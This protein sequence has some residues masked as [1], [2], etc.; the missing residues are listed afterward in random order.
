MTEPPRLP[1]ELLDMV[2]GHASDG[3]ADVKMLCNFSLVSSR[4]YAAL[5]GRIYS[6]WV[7]DGEHHS[8][9]SLWKFLRSVLTSRRIA[10]AVHELDIR[11]W[12]LGLV[13]KSGRLVF[14]D[15]DVD[16]IRNAL[17]V[18]GLERIESSA[19]EALQKADPRPLMA[20]LLA[21]LPNLTT[22][23]AHLPDEDMFFA[24]VLQKA[25]EGRQDKQASN[26]IPLLNRLC[27]VHLASAWNYRGRDYQLRVKHLSHV[28]QLPN[29]QE[30]SVFDLEPFEASDRFENSPRSSNITNLT[31]VH[32]TQSLLE[33]PDTLALLALPRRLTKLSIYLNDND[34][35]GYRNQISNIDLWSGIRKHEASLEHLDIYR[36]CDGD[37]PEC[38]SRN[39]SYFGL[40]RGFTRLRHLYIQPE[41]LL[42]GCCKGELAPF[43]LQDTLPPNLESLTLYGYEG[44]VFIKTLSQ[45]LEKVVTSTDFPLLGYVAMERKVPRPG[46]YCAR[47]TDPP[48]HHEVR[49]ACREVGKKYEIKDSPS[50]TRGGVGIPYY[51]HLQFK[52][53]RMAAKLQCV[54]YALT[55][56][57]SRLL[58][59]RDSDRG[60]VPQY[61]EFHLDDLDTYE[62]PWDELI[63]K[64][65]YVDEE[66]DSEREIEL[67][68]LYYESFPNGSKD[69]EI[70][71]HESDLQYLDSLQTDSEEDGSDSDG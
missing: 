5:S 56:Y 13:Y 19:L 20:L 16:L 47:P 26:G 59:L 35:D 61:R 68:E 40:M 9:L 60:Y 31:L 2:M 41:T 27:E 65:L 37:I 44:L 71:G 62:L 51:R 36:D 50:F 28:F 29:I 33:V 14:S 39:N 57:I 12:H 46:W 1:L 63:P 34:A 42:G 4:W 45:Q 24:A 18:A 69:E 64:H 70:N 32:H 10:D 11:N 3:M 23:Y 22:L 66:S 53:R 25:V 54:G 52:R 38:H 55:K 21:C 58:K 8:I 6:R 15:D 49:R 7:H 43:H 48:P 17:R 67:G 30:L